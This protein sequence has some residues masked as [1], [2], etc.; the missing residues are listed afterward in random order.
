MIAVHRGK[1]CLAEAHHSPDR[2]AEGQSLSL[3]PRNQVRPRR[4]SC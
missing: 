4:W 2:A 3:V 1:N